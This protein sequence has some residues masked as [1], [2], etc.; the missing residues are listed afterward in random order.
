MPR[1][2]VVVTP[3]EASAIGLLDAANTEEAM[4]YARDV[5]D[6]AISRS[7][8]PAADCVIQLLDKGKADRAHNASGRA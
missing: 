6:T 5:V 3:Y 2:V 7:N 8:R 4:G 1:Y